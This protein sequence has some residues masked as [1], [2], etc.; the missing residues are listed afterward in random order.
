MGDRSNVFIQM[1]Q[2]EDGLWAGIGVYSHWG[3]TGFQDAAIKEIPSASR[4]LGDPSY[5]TRILI[6]RLLNADADPD[7]ETGHGLWTE[8]P[9]DNEYPILVINAVS[10]EWGRVGDGA[11][12]L[13]LS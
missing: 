4:R 11:F 10:G 9:D 7:S 6:H 12:R 5:F 1:T 8:Q 13:S 3:G 2:G